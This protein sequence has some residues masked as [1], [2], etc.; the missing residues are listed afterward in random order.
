MKF[1]EIARMKNDMSFA[2]LCHSEAGQVCRLHKR[3][4]DGMASGTAAP[5]S[6]TDHCWDRRRT[7]NA[8]LIRLRKAGLFSREPVH[9]S[10]HDK[11]LSRRSALGS[12]R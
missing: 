4:R 7:R 12:P 6:M 11:P 8:G 3:T 10:A 2:E 1:A 5:I 9:L